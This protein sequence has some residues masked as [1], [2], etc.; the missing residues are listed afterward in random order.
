ML[1]EQMKRKW[2]REDAPRR[3]PYP[4]APSASSLHP[5]SWM[6]SPLCCWLHPTDP[7]LE[8]WPIIQR[9]ITASRNLSKAAVLCTLACLGV[10][11]TEQNG[12]Y[13]GPQN[14]TCIGLGCKCQNICLKIIL[15]SN[16]ALGFSIASSCAILT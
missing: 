8:P 15:Q 5:P 3:S 7:A 4:S 14:G 12:T 11:P 2:H 16:K 9:E 13:L 1:K 6:L 10:R